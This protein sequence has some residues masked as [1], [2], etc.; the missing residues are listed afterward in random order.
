MGG[1]AT[2]GW[3]SL[4]VRLGR[5]REARVTPEKNIKMLD[6]WKPAGLQGL[7]TKTGDW[8]DWQRVI[9]NEAKRVR[10]A[11]SARYLI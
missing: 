1:G 8:A 11:A 10:L 3:P 4:W 6:V 2:G 9:Y 7:Y 5:G